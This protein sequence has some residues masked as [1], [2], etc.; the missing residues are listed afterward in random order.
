MPNYIYTTNIPFATNNPSTDQPNMQTNT[1]SINSILLIDHYGFNDN[2]GGLH[3]QV[4]MPT[5]ASIPGSLMSGEG[6]LYTKTSG[7]SEL[8]FTPDLTGNE[9]QLTRTITASYSL[10]AKNVNNYNGVGTQFTGGWTFL[11][12]GIL[13]QYGSF[14]AGVGG[15]SSGNQSITFPVTFTNVPFNIQTSIIAK[16]GGTT[17]GNTVALNFSS[18][19]TTGFIVSITSSTSN[20]RGFSWVAIGI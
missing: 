5:L 17:T 13:L 20:Y 10:F 1:N 6:T 16:V 7:E 11:P 12:G 14:D 8:F 18:S 4:Q 9:Y 19:S 15:V 2:N 3:K